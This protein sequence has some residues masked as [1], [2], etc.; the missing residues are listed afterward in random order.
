MKFL[1]IA[2]LL[3]VSAFATNEIVCVESVS[4]ILIETH[5]LVDAYNRQEQ[6]PTLIEKILN[7]ARTIPN[8]GATCRGIQAKYQALPE[9]YG[10]IF[11]YSDDCWESI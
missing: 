10:T 8:L 7:I 4:E 6:I 9:T 2:T 5:E 3:L 11:S 1:L